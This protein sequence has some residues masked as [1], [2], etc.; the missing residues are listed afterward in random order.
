MK[1]EKVWIGTFITLWLL[2]S[3]ISTIHSVSFFELSNSKT[4]AWTL[5]ISF[6]IGAMASLGGLLLSRG[7]KI[8]IWVLF[9]ILTLFQIHSNMYWAWSNSEDINEWVN[10]FSLE[11]EDP[12]FRKRIFVFISGG[13]LPLISLGFIKSLMDYMKPSEII[14]I[15]KEISTNAT[16]EIEK[17][18]I[19]NSELKNI[20]KK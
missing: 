9:I 4:M 3:T 6:E 11:E 15:Q 20:F 1:F 19:N 17:K 10:L 5:A 7:S 18:N 2:V 12:M 8:L 14:D 13:I 16:N